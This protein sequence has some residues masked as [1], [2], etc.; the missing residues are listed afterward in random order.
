M[1][2]L[3]ERFRYHSHLVYGPG[4]AK[5][6]NPD[7]KIMFNKRGLKSKHASQIYKIDIEKNKNILCFLITIFIN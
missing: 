2:N 3:D 1:I 7:P 5:R 6:S 4:L